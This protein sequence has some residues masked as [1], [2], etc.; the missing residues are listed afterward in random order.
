VLGLGITGLVFGTLVASVV[1][2]AVALPSIDHRWSTAISRVMVVEALA[3]GIPLLPHALSHW[4]LALSDRLILG[5]NVGDAPVGVYGLAYQLTAVVTVIAVAVNQAVMPRYARAQSVRGEPGLRTLIT[6]QAL[7]VGFV[8]LATAV[9]GPPLVHLAL[10][11]SYQLAALV[12][13]PVALGFVFLGWYLIPMDSIVLVAGRTKWIF[14]C[15]V[16]AALTNIVL[17]L[18]L[19]PEF[20]VMA[21]SVNT[22][23]GYAVLL[24][25]VLAY[26]RSNQDSWAPV[27]W[28]GI[29]T[30]CGVMLAAYALASALT[31]QPDDVVAFAARTALLLLVVPLLVAI[32]IQR[33]ARD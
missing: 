24:V 22:A 3:F 13:P 1:L 2:V 5:A 32:V 11:A 33:R 17:N 25:L 16:V 12:I 4:A 9:L 20:G 7:L 30:G 31:P 28:A 14:V 19:V 15:S 29:L 21:A 27:D 6:S 8:G 23:V 26:G 10:P 18:L